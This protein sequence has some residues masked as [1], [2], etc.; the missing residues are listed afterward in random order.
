MQSGSGGPY[1]IH[2]LKVVWSRR[3]RWPLRESWWPLER[4]GRLYGDKCAE[5]G[6]GEVHCADASRPSAL[7]RLF[8]DA[9]P[10]AF[11][12]IVYY[13]YCFINIAKVLRSG[14][15][16]SPFIYSH[17]FNVVLMM[18]AFEPGIPARSRRVHWPTASDRIPDREWFSPCQ[19]STATTASVAPNTVTIIR[20]IVCWR[21]R[22]KVNISRVHRHY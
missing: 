21:E 17:A 11:S 10:A 16:N 12:F 4:Q 20:Q 8:V 13:I 1:S 9:T 5:R 2:F 22:S 7:S 3:A 15:F 6:T 14:S 18:T 19:P